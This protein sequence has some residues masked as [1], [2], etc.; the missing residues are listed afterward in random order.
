MKTNFK[1]ALVGFGI[2][3][4]QWLKTIRKV[5]ELQF[6]GIVENDINKIDDCKKNLKNGE[7]IFSSLENLLKYQCDCIILATPPKVHFNHIKFLK[8]FAIDIICE[9]PL[10][11]S[12]QSSLELKEIIKGANAELIVGMNFRYLN[13]SNKYKSLIESKSLGNVGYGTFKYLRNRNPH[14]IDLNK[15]PIDMIQPM[16]LEQTIH[17]ID[18]MRYCYQSEVKDVTAQTWRVPWSLYTNDCSVSILIN[19][20]NFHVNYIGT[21]TSGWNKLSFEWRTD[22]Q[23]GI[24]IQKDQFANL[25]YVEFDSKISMTGKNFKTAKD[26]E[27]LKKIKMTQ[28]K[29]LLSD[30][31]KYLQDYINY[32]LTGDR[33]QISLD[34]YLKS[35]AVIEACIESKN[36]RKTIDLTDYFKLIK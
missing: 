23:K 22:F 16:L 19:F 11:E 26:A 7:K 14:R 6:I 13:T 5:K 9:K 2:R 25:N 1:I 18:L 21:W 31:H 29:G 24:I 4:K 3:G 15:Y 35:C 27:V 28:D 20:D 12:F 33:M 30:T 32:K 17:H 10:T 36:K 34:D 8:D